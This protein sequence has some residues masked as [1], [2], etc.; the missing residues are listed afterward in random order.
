MQLRKIV[1]LFTPQFWMFVCALLLLSYGLTSVLL[2][3][4]H[5]DTGIELPLRVDGMDYSSVA[6]VSHEER[7]TNFA[8]LVQQPK[9]GVPTADDLLSARQDAIVQDFKNV[10][11]SQPL[12]PVFRHQLSIGVRVDYASA[13]AISLALQIDTY[14]SGGTVHTSYETYLIDKTEEKILDLTHEAANWTVSK[15]EKNQQP[16]ISLLPGYM[17]RNYNQTDN[18]RTNERFQDKPIGKELD[19]PQRWRE[20]FYPG[21]PKVLSLS[22]RVLIVAAQ[23]KLVKK[24]AQQAAKPEAEVVNCHEVACIALTFDDGPDART[25]PKLIDIFDKSQAKATFFVLGSRVGQNAE[26]L[27]RIQQEGF[28]IGNHSWNHIEFT[29]LSAKQMITQIQDTNTALGAAGVAYSQIFRPPYGSRNRLTGQ[30]VSEPI[31]IWNIDPRDWDAKTP[32]EVVDHIMT[33]ARSGA[34]VVMHDTH[35]LTVEAMEKSVPLL[36]QANF[37]LVTV[38]QLLGLQPG[39]RGEFSSLQ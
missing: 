6:I 11:Q 28:E 23:K 16:I 19:L 34:I 1:A 29:K 12:I 10:Q 8:I 24:R 2:R 37:K 5:A 22:Q 9:T 26:L 31:I 39:M 35:P 20:V 13:K 25:T 14:Y 17:V 30:V 36:K 33:H 4:M 15:N 27:R 38:S 32:D 7:N 18:D 21:Y 3:S